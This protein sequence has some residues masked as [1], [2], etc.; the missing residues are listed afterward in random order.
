[1]NADLQGILNYYGKRPIKDL[2]V[3]DDGYTLSAKEARV[4]IKY[5]LSLGH[6]ELKTCPDWDEVKDKL[7]I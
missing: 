4:Y 1:M 6:T 2:L 3:S 7:K 5:C